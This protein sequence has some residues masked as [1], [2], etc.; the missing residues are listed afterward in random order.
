MKKFKRLASCLMV[1]CIMSSLFAFRASAELGSVVASENLEA[2]SG[3]MTDRVEGTNFGWAFAGGDKQLFVAKDSDPKTKDYVLEGKQSLYFI[4]TGDKAVSAMDPLIT[5]FGKESAGDFKADKTYIARFLMKQIAPFNNKKSKLS[6]TVRTWAWEDKWVNY[7]FTADENG[8][9]NVKLDSSTAKMYEKAAMQKIDEDTY[10]VALRFNGVENTTN[11]YLLWHLEG[12][13]GF[14][15][16][17]LKIYESK[18]DPK[19][20]F[21]KQAVAPPTTTTSTPTTTTS[22]TATTAADNKTNANNT[23][24]PAG[25]TTAPAGGAEETSGL[26]TPAIVAIVIAGIAVVG[27]GAAAA[28]ILVRKKKK[29]E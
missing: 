28:I 8:D 20:A 25:A 2:A 13:G 24:A 17:D 4:N 10:E 26:S 5:V 21:E 11:C 27:A 18:D 15:I 14:S 1:G 6:I 23:T 16:D 19:K 3:K 7:D 29:A 22:E 9:L 12:E